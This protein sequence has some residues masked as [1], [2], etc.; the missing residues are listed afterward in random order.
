LPNSTISPGFAP[1]IGFTEP[2]V[3]ERAIRKGGNEGFNALERLPIFRVEQSNGNAVCAL[4]RAIQRHR[5][6]ENERVEVRRQPT[7]RECYES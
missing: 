5:E 3:T 7:S 6:Y 4:R 1:S 2:L